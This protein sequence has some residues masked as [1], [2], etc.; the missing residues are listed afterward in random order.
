VLYVNDGALE[1]ATVS[2]DAPEGG[3]GYRVV[4]R[5]EVDA[6][7]A[8][9]LADALGSLA[10]DG[11]KLVVLDASDVGF[12][13]S[14]GLR[15]IVNTGQALTSAGGRLV[16]DGMSPAVHRVLEVSGLLDQYRA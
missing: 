5:G 2:L 12:L 8:P 13:D 11:A 9:Q 16:I 4:A 15:V 1:L 7:T 14:S 10:D 3:P 6:A